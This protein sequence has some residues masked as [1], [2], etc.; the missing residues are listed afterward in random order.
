MLLLLLLPLRSAKPEDLIRLHDTL[1]HHAEE[2][3][4]LASRLGGRAGESL[5]DVA[6]A[7]QAGY[8]AGRCYYVG[9]AYLYGDKFVEAAA[10]FSRAAQRAD[11]ATEKLQVSDSVTQWWS[12][13]M[14]QVQVKQEYP[15]GVQL[16]MQNYMLT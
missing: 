5:T 4:E 14:L 15:A 2:L 16:F 6:Q 3:S 8:A 7:R 1:I 12:W 11:E 10:V 13:Q 9:H